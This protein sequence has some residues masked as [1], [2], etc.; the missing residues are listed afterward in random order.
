MKKLFLS[1]CILLLCPAFALAELDFSSYCVDDLYSIL[2]SVRAEIL[3]KSQWEEVTVPVG[4]YVVGED[5]PEGHWTIKYSPGEYSLIEYFHNTDSS[6]KRPADTIY[7]YYYDGI[8]D[9][10][11][12]LSSVYDLTEIDLVLQKGFHLVVNYGPVIFTPFTGRPSPFF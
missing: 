1:I 10:S 7:D 2:N 6:G 4:F 9:P 3:S 8:G 12:E 11:T 5:I